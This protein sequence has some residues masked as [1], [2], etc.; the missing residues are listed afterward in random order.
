[1]SSSFPKSLGTNS[2]HVD[3]I[4]EVTNAVVSSIS[5]STTFKTKRPTLPI[6]NGSSKIS[7]INFEYSRSN[8]PTRHLLEEGLAHLEKG[9]YGVALSSGSACTALLA[10]ICFKRA[11]TSNILCMSDVYGGT[12]RYLTKLFKNVEFCDMTNLNKLKSAMTKKVPL[13]WIETPTNPTRI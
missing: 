8:N 2:V 3:E 11:P 7:K 4:D 13:V 5:L 10:E 9:K 12:Y 6:K 1:M